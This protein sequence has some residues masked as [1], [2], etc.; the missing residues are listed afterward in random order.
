MGLG[1]D[2][3]IVLLA[4]VTNPALIGLAESPWIALATGSQVAVGLSLVAYAVAAPWPAMRRLALL[5][6]GGAVIFLPSLLSRCARAPQDIMADTTKV[7]T[8]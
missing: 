7:N 4:M 8:L 5:V 2:L 6:A 3:Y 1:I